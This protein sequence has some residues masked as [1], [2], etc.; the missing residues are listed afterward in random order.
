MQNRV[1]WSRIILQRII[2]INLDSLNWTWEAGADAG[3]LGFL[4][5]CWG[6]VFLGG[7]CL[8]PL[9][10][11]IESWQFPGPALT[12]PCSRQSHLVRDKYASVPALTH[13][14]HL[15]RAPSLI[16]V[17]SPLFPLWVYR[18]GVLDF[19]CC[20]FPP[21]FTRFCVLGLD[22]RKLGWVSGER[23]DHKSPCSRP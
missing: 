5:P 1:G 21:D 11:G 17:Y 12:L 20:F 15:R 8:V 16:L 10:R 2:F 14:Y 9:G 18:C 19:C 13:S 6:D 4:A 3:L 22:C 7:R 23:G